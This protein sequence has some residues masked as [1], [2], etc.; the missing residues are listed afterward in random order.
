M[1]NLHAYLILFVCSVQPG[2]LKPPPLVDALQYFAERSIILTVVCSHKSI[3]AH[4]RS[5]ITPPRF[6][7]PV[8]L[9]NSQSALTISWWISCLKIGWGTRMD[10]YSSSSWTFLP[11]RHDLLLQ[12]T[13]IFLEQALKKS[14]H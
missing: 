6:L 14:R 5:R 4:A 7:F 3:K 13:A 8:T 12:S 1:S 10:K 11:D 2:I 9:Q